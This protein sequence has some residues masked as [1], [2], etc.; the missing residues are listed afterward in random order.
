MLVKALN[1]E[2]GR[3]NIPVL[4]ETTAK[5]ILINDEGAVCGVVAEDKNGKEMTIDCTASDSG[6]RR[7][8]RQC[9]DGRGV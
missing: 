9:R 1:N 7:F 3:V 8:W 6:N 4:L 2:D 5:Q